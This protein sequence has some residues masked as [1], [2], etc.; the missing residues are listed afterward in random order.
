MVLRAGINSKRFVASGLVRKKKRNHRQIAKTVFPRLTKRSYSSVKPAEFFAFAVA[1]DAFRSARFLAHLSRCLLWIVTD[2]LDTGMEKPRRIIMMPKK[3][4]KKKKGRVFKLHGRSAVVRNHVHNTCC[5]RSK[6]SKRSSLTS[7]YT[8][9]RCCEPRQ[10][11]PHYLNP[12][13][14]KQVP[15]FSGPTYNGSYK[16]Q[17]WHV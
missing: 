8:R 9:C 10:R 7:Q 1:I 12:S 17:H 2:I 11:Q 3:E 4:E 6:S 5:I 14:L 15:Q 13:N 16:P